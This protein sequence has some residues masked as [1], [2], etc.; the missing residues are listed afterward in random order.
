MYTHTHT[1]TFIYIHVGGG[2][3]GYPLQ[4]YAPLQKHP[5]PHHIPSDTILYNAE[6]RILKSILLL[7]TCPLT[8]CSL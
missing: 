4:K 5:P 8:P 6:A 7:T 2:I 1:H 3:G